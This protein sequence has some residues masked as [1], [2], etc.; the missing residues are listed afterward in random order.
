MVVLTACSPLPESNSL[1]ASGLGRMSGLRAVV[2][3]LG[4]EPPS[5]RRRS[6]MYWYSTLSCAGRK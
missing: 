2:V 3:R 5:A 1:N 4:T 6:I